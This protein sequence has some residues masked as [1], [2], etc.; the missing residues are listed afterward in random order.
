MRAGAS[1]LPSS[2]RENRHGERT[3]RGRRRRLLVQSPA[4]TG[5][6]LVPRYTDVPL[7]VTSV[8]LL[9]TDWISATRIWTSGR[10]VVYPRRVRGITV[11]FR[12][13]WDSEFKT[14]DKEKND[15]SIYNCQI[16]LAGT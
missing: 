15:V 6:T 7:Q 10:G 12:R 13:L 2:S 11:G 5:D 14:C 3:L 1:P 9:M 8:F 4:D 16:I